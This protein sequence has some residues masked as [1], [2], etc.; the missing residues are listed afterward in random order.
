M[1]SLCSLLT[2]IY[3]M[4]AARNMIKSGF[5]NT[6]ISELTDIPLQEVQR[7]VEAV[8]IEPNN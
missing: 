1:L 2:L 7:F 8:A 5:S 6:Q 3:I 4:S